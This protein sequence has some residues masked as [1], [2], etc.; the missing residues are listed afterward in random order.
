MAAQLVASRVVLSPIELYSFLVSYCS[1][2]VPLL[3]QPPLWSTSESYLQKNLVLFLQNM[4]ELLPHCHRMLQSK[5]NHNKY[6]GITQVIATVPSCLPWR[7]AEITSTLF[8]YLV[9]FIYLFVYRQIISSDSLHTTTCEAVSPFWSQ[10]LYFLHLR[11][12]ILSTWRLLFILYSKVVI[13]I[14]FVIQTVLVIS[15]GFPWM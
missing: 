4:N 14:E 8:T 12:C 13:T 1:N 7:N 6:L 11:V 2:I 9:L 10:I 3:T 15:I 5:N